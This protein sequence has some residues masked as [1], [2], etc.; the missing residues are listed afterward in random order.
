MSLALAVGLASAALR[1]LTAGFILLHQILLEPD[2]PN[3]PNARPAVRYAMFLLGAALLF[4]SVDL[5]SRTIS[6]PH[7]RVLIS[8]LPLSAVWCVAEALRLEKTLRSWLP[9]RLQQRVQKW[10]LLASCR[11]RD[12]LARERQRNLA[13]VRGTAFAAPAGVVGPA[14]GELALSEGLADIVGPQE[15]PPATFGERLRDVFP[16]RAADHLVPDELREL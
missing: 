12:A 15:E 5:L 13:A 9:V 11:N 4:N 6:D 14:L 8:G 1:F 2:R 3:Y 7:H 10:W 16:L